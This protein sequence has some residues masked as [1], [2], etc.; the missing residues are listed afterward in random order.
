MAYCLIQSI[1]LLFFESAVER[2][3]YLISIGATLGPS[4]GVSG[5]VP[6]LRVFHMLAFL[7]VATSFS[8]LAWECMYKLILA[9]FIA[10]QDLVKQ[11]ELKV[12]S[13]SYQAYERWIYIR[14]F[15]IIRVVQVL[16]AVIGFVTVIFFPN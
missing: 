10:Y 1:E 4:L 2:I 15:W 6:Q 11:N 16:C 13:D 3:D 14:C 5:K 7:R 9:F 8:F 12:L